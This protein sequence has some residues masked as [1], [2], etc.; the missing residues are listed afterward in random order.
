MSTRINCIDRIAV[1]VGVGLLVQVGVAG[2]EPADL[3]VIEAAPNQR[4]P[5]IAF[6]P[7]ARGCPEPVGARAAPGACDRLPEG[8]E[9]QAGRHTLA[10]VRHRPCARLLLEINLIVPCVLWAVSTDSEQDRCFPLL[11]VLLRLQ[12]RPQSARGWGFYGVI[13]ARG[14]SARCP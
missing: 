12:R 2:E 9:R 6:R 8:R 13:I 4:Q 1:A 3:R 5:R 11:Q 7:V 14:E 10:A